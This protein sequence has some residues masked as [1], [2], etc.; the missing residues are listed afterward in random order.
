MEAA[1]VEPHQTSFP[2]RCQP[3]HPRDEHALWQQDWRLYLGDRRSARLYRLPEFHPPLA[4]RHAPLGGSVALF[5]STGYLGFLFYVNLSSYVSSAVKSN[6]ALMNYPRVAPFDAIVSRVVLQFSTTAVVT[7]LTLFTL[8]EGLGGLPSVDW[9]TIIE[10]AVST[11]MIAIGI[12]LINAGLFV[13][14]PWYEEVFSIVNRPLFIL[15]GVFMLPDELPHPYSDYFLMNPLVH[16]VIW[17]RT[18]FYPEYRAYGLD[19]GYVLETGIL[20]MLVG[21]ALFT[22]HKKMI[23]NSD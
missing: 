5:I 3:Y 15:S 21:M 11:S 22:I 19:K 23:K 12:G 4:Q 18:G 8:A 7:A 9:P 13:R 16:C 1:A 14:W 10:A 2:G 6:K 17:F 20:L